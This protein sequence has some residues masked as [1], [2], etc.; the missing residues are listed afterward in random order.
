[1]GLYLVVRGRN[2]NQ[3]YHIYIFTGEV[4]YGT[5]NIFTNSQYEIWFQQLWDQFSTII[6]NT[7]HHD[8]NC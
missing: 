1:M 4:Q 8:V 7:T 6:I 2:H 5:P 3:E